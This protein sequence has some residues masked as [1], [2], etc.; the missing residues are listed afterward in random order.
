M[1]MVEIMLSIPTAVFLFRFILQIEYFDGLNMLCIFIVSAI[2]AVSSRIL[3]GNS[4][5]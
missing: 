4:S 5:I 1:G 3:L 2:G